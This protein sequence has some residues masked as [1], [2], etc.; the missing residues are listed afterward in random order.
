MPT[1]LDKSQRL[2]FRLRPTLGRVHREFTATRGISTMLLRTKDSDLARR[3]VAIRRLSKK[4]FAGWVTKQPSRLWEYPWVVR[5]VERRI[6]GRTRSAMDAGAGKSPV[7]IALARLGLETVVVDPGTPRPRTG[8]PVRGS[9]WEWT[10]YSKFGVRSVQGRMEDAVVPPRSLGFV[11]SVSAIE[12]LCA[13]LRR[14][15]LAR[16]AEALE[17][18]GVLVLT[19]D[20]FPESSDL[21]NRCLG[22][23]VEAREEH[24][25]AETL[26][27]EAAA[28][29]ME[30]QTRQRCPLPPGRVDV[31]GF[32]FIRRDCRLSAEHGN[33]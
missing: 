4:A 20:V 12:H 14:A 33:R 13:E 27:G 26:I 8:E 5:E 18:A 1:G 30:L 28:V 11:V 17:P 31:E 2:Y 7:P 22:E 3:G 10:D 16:L 23:I 29:G 25:C 21:W 15:A 9:E 32:V 24:G 6:G 19:V